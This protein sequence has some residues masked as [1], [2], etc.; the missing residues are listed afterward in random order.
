MNSKTINL[1]DEAEKIVARYIK[2]NMKNNNRKDF[3][4][5]GA[6]AANLGMLLG[7]VLVSLI[8]YRLL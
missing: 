8:L 4:K 2:K 5:V 6:W 7:C 3:R 1:A